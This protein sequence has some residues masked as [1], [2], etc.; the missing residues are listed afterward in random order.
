LRHTIS[1]FVCP[2]KSGSLCEPGAR[3]IELFQ[4]LVWISESYA[5]AIRVAKE[6][7][8]VKVR[9]DTY[10]LESQEVVISLKGQAS[11]NPE[12]VLQPSWPELVGW[13]K[14]IPSCR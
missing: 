11:E 8:R 14:G 12:E 2:K 3:D 9:L 10:Q 13:W 5:S 1:S 4:N 6:E 7:R